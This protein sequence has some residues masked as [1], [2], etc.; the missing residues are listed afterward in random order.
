M[1]LALPHEARQMAESLEAEGN[2][3]IEVWSF[4]QGEFSRWKSLVR[5]QNDVIG[6]ASETSMNFVINNEMF[7][8]EL[9][10]VR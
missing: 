7:M 2:T 9:E 1:L 6:E 3:R 5:E 10:R 8:T 4:R